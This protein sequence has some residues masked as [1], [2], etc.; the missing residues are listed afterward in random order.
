MVLFILKIV[1]FW[2]PI[3]YPLDFL[4]DRTIDSLCGVLFQL[5]SCII[6]NQLFKGGGTPH[7]KLDVL[8]G[9]P[10]GLLSENG[11]ISQ[12]QPLSDRAF[13]LITAAS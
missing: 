9:G 6:A 1:G 3:G 13:G 8:W 4:V 10:S 2:F 5:T 12:F 7:N 11:A